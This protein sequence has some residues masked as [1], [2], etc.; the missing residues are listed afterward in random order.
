[1]D[2]FVTLEFIQVKTRPPAHLIPRYLNFPPLPREG[3]VLVVCARRV[4]AAA[5]EPS[6]SAPTDPVTAVTRSE[7]AA[8]GRPLLF[9]TTEHDKLINAAQA[10]K[11]LESVFFFP[12]LLCVQGLRTRAF[13]ARER[14][15]TQE[16]DER[17]MRHGGWAV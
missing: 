14:F 16:A 10:S 9:C 11:V 7:V 12:L 2:C 1:M 15:T 8:V 13:G 17:E 4:S 6:S 5:R 3:M